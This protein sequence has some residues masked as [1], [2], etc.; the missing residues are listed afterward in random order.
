MF[1]IE[2]EHERHIKEYNEAG[3]FDFDSEKFISF[4]MLRN[5]L[6]EGERK[7]YNYLEERNARWSTP[8]DR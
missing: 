2:N 5:M 4:G 8:E 6:T 7:I 3:A 1:A